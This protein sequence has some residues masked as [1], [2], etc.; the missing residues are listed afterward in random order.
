M[1]NWQLLWFVF[2]CHAICCWLRQTKVREQGR[3]APHSYCLTGYAEVEIQAEL[4]K[5]DRGQNKP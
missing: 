1:K 4:A 5:A 3:K 2:G